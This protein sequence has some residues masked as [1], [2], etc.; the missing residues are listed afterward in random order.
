MTRALS[1]RRRVV[2]VLA[3]LATAL[4]GTLAAVA[5]VLDGCV[6]VHA[7]PPTSVAAAT[8]F[9]AEPQALLQSLP[10]HP[11]SPLPLPR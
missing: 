11:A 6:P 8:R 4:V 3:A 7:L 10:Q 2:D 5:T 9:A 1:E